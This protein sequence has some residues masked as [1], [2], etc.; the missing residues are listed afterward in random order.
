[1]T[2][3]KPNLIWI[4]TGLTLLGCLLH[5]GIGTNIWYSPTAIIQE[6]FHGYHPGESTQNDVIWTFRLP[7]VLTCL[8][9]GGSLGLC[10]AVLQTLFRNPL[11]EPYI[12]G[13]S[14][15]AAIGGALIGTIVTSG[16]ALLLAKPL[17]G[18]AT[19]LLTLLLVFRLARRN[20]VVETPSLLLAGVVVSTMLS[21]LLTL[22]VLESGQDTNRVL[23]WLLGSL[24]ETQWPSV[25]LLAIAFGIG[26]AIL[27]RSSRQINALSVGEET[28]A[29]VGVDVHKLRNVVLVTVTGLIA[30]TV[31]PVG[32]IGFVGLVA[33]HIARSL[34]GVDLRKS[35]PLSTLCGAMVLIFADLIAQRGPQGT[36]LPVGIVTALIGAPSLLILMG[37]R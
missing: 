2:K 24:A 11:A 32:I 27:Y 9:V 17:A 8:F 7:R 37:R 29:S 22:I 33:P 31:G 14:S 23:R 35:I 15:G 26:Y 19:G 34:V 28:A 25:W 10:G 13:A 6:L 16:T 18:F 36:Q 12:V 1:M 4:A 3:A 5:L 30:T 20:G 21:S